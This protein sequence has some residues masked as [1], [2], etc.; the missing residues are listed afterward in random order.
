MKTK[1]RK[2]VMIVQQREWIARVLL[3]FLFVGLPTLLNAQGATTTFAG[4]DATLSPLRNKIVNVITVIVTSLAI[5]VMLIKP[6]ILGITYAMHDDEERGQ[7]AMKKLKAGIGKVALG[8]GIALS[9]GVIGNY[10]VK[11]LL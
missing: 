7:E 8:C 9:A 2:N 6:A 11:G 1:T 5:G 4:E 10:L 3:V